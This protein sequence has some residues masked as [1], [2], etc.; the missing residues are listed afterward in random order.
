LQWKK[1]HKLHVS[2]RD[3][4]DAYRHGDVDHLH[5]KAVKK[6]RAKLSVSVHSI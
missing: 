5:K 2:N 4:V 6:L 1:K 3:N